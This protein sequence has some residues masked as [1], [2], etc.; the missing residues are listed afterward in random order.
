MKVSNPL[1][2]KSRNFISA[3]LRAGLRIAKYDLE[4]VD[5][6]HKQTARYFQKKIRAFRTESASQPDSYWKQ[7][8]GG[9]TRGEIASE[10]L[11]ELE[12]LAQ[13]NNRFGILGVFATFERLLLR[14][15]QDMMN[16]R[17]V[18]KERFKKDY[19]TFDLYKDSL[20]AI[21]IKLTKPPFDWANL[22]KLQTLRN[23]ITHQ[24]GV[25]T[26]DNVEDLKNYGYKSVGQSIDITDSYF[27]D[28]LNLVKQSCS[29]LVKGYSEMLSKITHRSH[30]KAVPFD[31]LAVAASLVAVYFLW[32]GVTK[33]SAPL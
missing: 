33:K 21:G 10:K 23:A 22:R 2:P 5:E 30:R 12:T 20:A 27:E 8:V 9:M 28:S 4:T 29:Q 26:E 15:H 14:I 1:T 7:D 3:S 19:L 16:L 32:R 18:H 25:V 24:D 17:L 31:M 11:N 13:M 6:F